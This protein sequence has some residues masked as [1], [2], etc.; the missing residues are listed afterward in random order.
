[1][2]RRHADNTTTE[3]WRDMRD[4]IVPAIAIAERH[5][6]VLAI[7]PEVGNVVHSPAAARRLLD[8]IESARL[9]VVIDA[10]NL[11]DAEDPSR[12]IANSEEV[13][14]AAFDLLAGDIVLAHA[15]DVTAEGSFAAAGRGD[16]DW[17]RYLMLLDASGYTGALV[18]HGLDE[19]DVAGSTAFL[20]EHLNARA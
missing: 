13:L 17:E 10:A 11:F 16:V 8:E 18:M 7:E 15:K 14:T 3:A 6:V 20:A 9:G 19:A 5:D 12:R 4:T 2:W 1:M